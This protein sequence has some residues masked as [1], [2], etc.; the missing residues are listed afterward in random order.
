MQV[1]QSASIGREFG[2]R[3]QGYADCCL[4]HATSEQ[5][6]GDQSM[7]GEDLPQFRD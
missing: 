2:S 6:R 3:V 5:T 1:L 4:I 7:W